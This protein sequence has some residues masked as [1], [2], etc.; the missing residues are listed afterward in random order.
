M[1]ESVANLPFREA[2]D[3]YKTKVPM[4]QGAFR[5]MEETH[6]HKAFVVSGATQ[7]AM[8]E[9]LYNAVADARDKGEGWADFHQRFDS[10]KGKYG[11]SHTGKPEWRS[12]L[13]WDTNVTQ[14]YNAGRYRQ[15]VALKALRP[16]WRYRHTSFENP[17]P[18]HQGWDGRVVAADDPWWNT[19]FPQNG[20][21]CKCKVDALSRQEA[22]REWKKH[23]KEG[24]DTPEVEWEEITVGQM[25]GEPR[26]VRT[27]IG[28]DPGFGFNPGKAWLEPHAV[29]PIQGSGAIKKRAGPWPKG[30]TPPDMPKPTRIP[31][32]ALLPK[33]TPPEKAVAGFLTKFGAD[34]ENGAVFKDA[35]GTHIAID[36]ALFQDGKGDFAWLAGA[37]GNERI[38][39]LLL[40]ADAL[41]A[42]DEVWW[43]WEQDEGGR[44]RWQLKRR[45]LKALEIEGSSEYAAVAFE[46]GKKG[47]GGSVDFATSKDNLDALFHKIQKGKLAFKK[48]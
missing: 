34:M 24:P 9:D 43:N 22:E 41:E 32:D 10:I 31:K 7:T 33:D 38:A 27:P 42:P 19:H 13:I 11:W 16:Y 35:T 23:G 6:R 8:L 47:W 2:I 45:Y 3:H 1:P 39:H 44:R 15:M 25:S 4:T 26:V 46:W 37:E 17:R 14:S 30:F 28:I 40:F 20:F 36:K 5:K 29:P 48:K 21:L 18:I 12:R